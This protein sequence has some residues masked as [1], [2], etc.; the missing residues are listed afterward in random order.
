VAAIDGY[1]K[2]KKL[3]VSHS[4]ALTA[5]QKKFTLHRAA[6]TDSTGA[7]PHL[8]L[9]TGIQADFDDIR[10]LAS[11]LDT[12]L[13]F[14]LEPTGDSSV[15]TAWVKSDWADGD[16]DIYLIYENASATAASSA[17]EVAS[18]NQGDS[19][20]GSSLDTDIWDTSGAGSVVISGGE[21]VITGQISMAMKTALGTGYAFRARMKT[22]YWDAQVSGGSQVIGFTYETGNVQ[23]NFSHYSATFK[24]SPHS[25]GE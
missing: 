6:G 17:E 1:A 8:Y 4:G 18:S 19:F 2:A 5:Y 3:T 25:D 11:D 23:Q 15:V 10:F 9:G 22:N 13:P 12:A 7:D 20:P 14:V 16:T 24:K 21:A